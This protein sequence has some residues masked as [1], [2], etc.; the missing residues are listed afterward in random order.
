MESAPALVD[1]PEVGQTGGGTTE[2]SPTD[3]VMARTSEPKLPA[4]ST[5]GGSAPEGAPVAEEVP[6]ASIGMT[7]MVALVDPSIRARPSLSLVWTGDDPL[8]WGR[9]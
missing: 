8:T 3:A 6:S 4:S 5:I 7:P 1:A 2:A 9:N